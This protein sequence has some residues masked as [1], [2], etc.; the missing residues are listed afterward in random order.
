MFVRL[1][2]VMCNAKSSIYLFDQLA[3]VTVQSNVSKITCSK[4]L[5]MSSMC[6]VVGVQLGNDNFVAF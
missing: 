3:E 4:T 5:S 6:P 1:H 2:L